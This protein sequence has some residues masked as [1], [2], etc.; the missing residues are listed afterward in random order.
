MLLFPIVSGLCIRVKH[1][2]LF[3]QINSS[4][5]GK[6]RFVSASQVKTGKEVITN[7]KTVY[8]GIDLELIDHRLYN[9]INSM[10]DKGLFSFEESIKK[11]PDSVQFKFNLNQDTFIEC[12]D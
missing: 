12:K 3:H 7:H 6:I 5:L 10:I 4:T 1:V 11:N 2:H 8:F 9:W